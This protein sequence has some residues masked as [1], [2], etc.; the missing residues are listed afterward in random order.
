M[1]S[2]KTLV[3][4]FVFGVPGQVPSLELVDQ[5]KLNFM[6]ILKCVRKQ[7]ALSVGRLGEEY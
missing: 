3:N 7:E 4:K 2:I 6:I 5:Y 1:S